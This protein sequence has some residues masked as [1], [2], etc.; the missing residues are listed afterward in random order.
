MHFQVD[1]IIVLYYGGY[2]TSR[3]G[4]WHLNRIHSMK[5]AEVINASLSVASTEVDYSQALVNPGPA[6]ALPW[7]FA[8]S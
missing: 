5:N 4:E 8:P 3:I 1:I 6:L 7:S 2:R